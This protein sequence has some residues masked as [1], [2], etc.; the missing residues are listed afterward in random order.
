MVETGSTA[1]VGTKPI[2]T[3]RTKFRFNVSK[4][5]AECLKLQKKGVDLTIIDHD[6]GATAQFSDPDGNRCALRSDAGFGA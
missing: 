4:L 6:W 5:Q 1:H 3:C 2:D